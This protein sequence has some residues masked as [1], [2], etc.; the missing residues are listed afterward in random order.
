MS[1]EPTER[2]PDLDSDDAEERK[3]KTVNPMDLVY[4]G[5]Y[6]GDPRELV[7]NPAVTP[8]MLNEPGDLRAD[9][10]NED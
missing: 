6:V 4:S 2:L 8:E 3:A 9:E 7:K 10:M 1:T 5:G